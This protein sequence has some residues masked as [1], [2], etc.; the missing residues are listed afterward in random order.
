MSWLCCSLTPSHPRGLHLSFQHVLSS[1][2]VRAQAALVHLLPEF[3]N[4]P[5]LS[6]SLVLSTREQCQSPRSGRRA[7]VDNGDCFY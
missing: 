7:L 6:G 3:Q 5:F 2:T 4:Q 1:G